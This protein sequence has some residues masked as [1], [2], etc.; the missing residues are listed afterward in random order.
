[1]SGAQPPRSEIPGKALAAIA[2]TS[3]AVCVSLDLFFFGPTPTFPDEGR[4]LAAATGLVNNLQFRVGRAVA[5]EMPGTALF[6]APLRLAFPDHA[7]SAIRIAQ[8]SLVATQS[9]MI[10]TLAALLF[11]DRLTAI[12]AATIAAVYP[13]F[14]FYQGLALSETLFSFLLVAGFLGLYHWRQ[15]GAAIELW[16]VL[17]VV[18]LTFAT[19]TKATLTVL[20]PLLLV[21]GA[22]GVQ[23][24]RTLLRIFATASLLYAVLMSPW[25]IRNYT[26]LGA[27][28]PFTTSAAANFY[29]GNSPNNP[30]A[31]TD[32]SV[33]KDR[34]K[35]DG[36]LERAH[37][38]QNRALSFILAE[39]AEFARRA[40]IKFFRFWNVIP[41]A[42]Q[43]RGPVYRWL[44]L[45]TFGP[46]LLLA[47]VC[48]LTRRAE[49]VKFLPIYSLIGYMTVLHVVT[50]ASLRYRLP[51]E[52]FLIA[53][54]AHPLANLFHHINRY[55]AH[56]HNRTASP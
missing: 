16:L 26:L 40:T 47:I 27:F 5:W 21:F 1:M 3:F 31:G 36:E 24:V 8:A 30:R 19:L 29:L 44:S 54:G 7:L 56:T 55:R 28:V 45:L 43:Y 4:F 14:L 39:P 53:M 2:F 49:F 17:P 11:R 18:I 51:I 38:F 13:F 48:S 23:P 35:E 10:G 42:D 41:N 25:W 6:F 32:W 20:P 15:R 34:P 50:I 33:E 9:A 22:V 12:L 52:P 37:V 46:V